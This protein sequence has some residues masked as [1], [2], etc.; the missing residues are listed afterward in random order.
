MYQTEENSLHN[1]RPVH[2]Y[3]SRAA[4]DSAVVNCCLFIILSWDLMI[5]KISKGNGMYLCVSLT[6]SHHGSM[7][8]N[9]NFN[10]G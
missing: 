2:A 6:S 4:D 3:E 9:W 5:L 8:K 7:I 10:S 1:C